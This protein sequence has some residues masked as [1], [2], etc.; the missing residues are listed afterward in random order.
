MAQDAVSEADQRL[1][2]EF[3]VELDRH[4]LETCC[5]CLQRWF[6]MDLSDKVCK[7]CRFKDQDCN[8]LKT[9]CDTGMRVTSSSGTRA[10]RAEP[11]RPPH[12]TKTSHP[13]I[14][15]QRGKN[16]SCTN[17]SQYY[18][19]RTSLPSTVLRDILTKTLIKFPFILLKTICGSV[20]SPN[21]SLSYPN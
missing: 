12:E 8:E 9:G 21:I 17:L 11:P 6:G 1:I 3:A 13:R 15:R 16:Q 14:A 7:N 18:Q 2:R 19:R 10:A 5:R 20:L 4:Q